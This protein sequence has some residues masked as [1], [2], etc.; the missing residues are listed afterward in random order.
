MVRRLE[1]RY[2]RPRLRHEIIL[3]IFNKA[4]R[5]KDVPEFIWL[6]IILV[7]TAISHQIY[8]RQGTC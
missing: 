3:T 2:Q 4:I 5:S 6:R 1:L 8:K 7:N